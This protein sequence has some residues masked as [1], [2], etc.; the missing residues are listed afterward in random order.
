MS[1][2][3]DQLITELRVLGEERLVVGSA[4]NAS[5]RDGKQMWISRTGCRLSRAERREFTAMDHAGKVVDG[6][7]PSKEHPLHAAIY[8]R[9]P[10]YGCIIHLHSTYSVA[11]SCLVPTDPRNVF[12]PLTP[13]SVMRLGA[14][15][16][17]P[18]HRPGASSVA[19]DIAQ[20]APGTRAALLS[21]HGMVV[22]GDTP[23]EVAAMAVEL[24]EVAQLSMILRGHGSRVLDADAVAELER[25][26]PQRRGS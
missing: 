9:G 7:V 22:W 15:P 5:V 14:V 21:N 16:L 1:D 11:V 20:C 10:E 17:I 18:Y 26:F 13:Y 4:G 23:H 8:A 24:E 6:P 3:L 25:S 12:P 2:R 19:D